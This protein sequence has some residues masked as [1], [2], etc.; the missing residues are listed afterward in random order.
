MELE[1]K[2]INKKKRLL[3]MTLLIIF[4]VVSM[5]LV[6]LLSRFFLNV[7]P[8]DDVVERLITLTGEDLSEVLYCGTHIIIAI[9][10]GGIWAEITV[11]RAIKFRDTNNLPSIQKIA[12]GVRDEIWLQISIMLI[13]S[14]MFLWTSGFGSDET[15]GEVF[16]FIGILLAILGGVLLFP[17]CAEVFYWDDIS[18]KKKKGLYG[19]ELN[20][21]RKRSRVVDAWYRPQL[22]ELKMA[23]NNLRQNYDNAEKFEI[24]LKNLKELVNNSDS[25]PVIDLH[26]FRKYY[27]V[28]GGDYL[29]EGI[30]DLRRVYSDI[31]DVMRPERR[32]E[33]VMQ[34]IDSLENKVKWTLKSNQSAVLYNL[35]MERIM[36]RRTSN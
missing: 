9:I 31:D 2:T 20:W 21:L 8:V 24:S 23:F 25:D 32:K 6:L 3:Y 19:D 14:M 12:K 16:K 28:I 34:K 29:E 26:G 5:G 1:K 17:F 10:Y 27:G 35:K 30:S 7:I 13:F 22:K 18:K 36:E 15:T 11:R 4:N 33:I